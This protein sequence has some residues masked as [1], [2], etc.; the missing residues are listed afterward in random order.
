M[1]PLL[2]QTRC[3]LRND[4]RLLW[5]DLRTGKMRLMGSALLIGAV[6]LILH[7][8][9]VLVFSQIDRTPPLAIEAGVWAFFAF[10]MLGAS[11]N[12]AISLFFERADFDLLLSAPVSTRAVLLARLTGLAV[13]ACLGAALL[14]MPLLDGI[15]L[16]YSANYVAGYV[17]W[18]LLA[19]IAACAGVWFTLGLVRLLGARRA[20][21]W[22]QVIGAVL[23]ASVYLGFQLQ[24]HAEPGRKAAFLAAARTVIDATGFTDLAR[25]GRGEFFPL[26]LLFVLSSAA[27][28]LTARL[29][30]RTFL[31]GMQESGA[32]PS[33][34]RRTDGVRYRLKSGLARA[35]FLKDLRLIVRDPLLL[36]QVLPS[37]M[38]IL[39]VFFGIRKL[40][41]VALLAPVAIVLAVQFSTILSE[42]AAAG[43][44][45]LDLIRAS[46]SPEI[47]LR[48]AKMAA[49]M[50]LPLGASLLVC[51]ALAGFGRPW[52][53]LLTFATGLTTAA[54]AS[55][56]TVAR[57][58][59]TPRK[60]L[61]SR[62]RKR[63]SLGRS[64]AIGALIIGACTGIS[65]IAQ[66]SLWLLGL[67][68][69]GITALGVIACFTLVGIEEIDAES[70][71]PP[72]THPPATAS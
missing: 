13:S 60:D 50:A 23:G 5:R 54:G 61:M 33:I 6:L 31:T 70:A 40:G 11:M 46:P 69:L 30:A 20:R 10:L 36:S 26:L 2:R 52:L 9:S 39:P 12:Q 65:L 47:R 63:T 53:A 3:I 43:E 45:C 17:V 49:G 7:V 41:G 21:V 42:V 67:L 28:W 29:L 19:V 32:R 51:V 58:S 22:V 35:T 48:L 27:A 72:W 24:Q 38:Y 71:A 15:I 4:L 66:G 68:A 1:S 18:G 34:R 44:E 57:V 64:V 59:P 16:G 8:I 37:L 14:L 55:W 25:G 62:G 56:L